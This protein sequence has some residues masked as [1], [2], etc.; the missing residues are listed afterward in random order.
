MSLSFHPL[1]RALGVE[2]RG[3]DLALPMAEET[4]EILLRAFHAFHLI[5]FKRQ[6]LTEAQ[7]I[8]FSAWF[9]RPSRQGA[10][11][12][13]AAAVTHVSNVR[14]DGTFGVGELGFHADQTYFEFPMK[15][16]ML[17]GIDVPARGGD[18]IF[19]SATRAYARLPPALQARIAGLRARHHFDYGALQ[20][21]AAKKAEVA[22]LKVSAV[23]PVV[24]AHPV[25]GAP[26]LF[27]NPSNTDR[28]LDLP[29]AEAEALLQELCAHIAA[30]DNLYTHRWEPGD[31]VVWDNL[32]LQHARSDF[33]NEQ[34]RTLRR[35]AIAHD[36][37]PV[38]DAA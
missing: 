24:N 37:E 4:A 13:T 16:I 35:I 3:L 21:G 11:Q 27:V 22:A 15:A 33:P 32:A 17:Y 23:H 38:A 9:G 5:S 31:L 30:P 36:R 1:S 7:Q 12:K 19:A 28:I 25:T 8:R 29:H 10:I 14:A 34:P 20:Y 26:I 18:T 6:R 2:V